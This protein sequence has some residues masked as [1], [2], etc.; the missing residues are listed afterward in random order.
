MTPEQEQSIAHLEDYFLRLATSRKA[1]PAVRVIELA[2]LMLDV[3]AIAEVRSGL[4]L[5]LAE[6]VLQLSASSNGS[7]KS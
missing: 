1:E 6:L 3:S 7:G 5:F 2:R 4:S